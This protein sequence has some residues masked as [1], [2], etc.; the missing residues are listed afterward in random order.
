SVK[1]SPYNTL[2]RDCQKRLVFRQNLGWRQV[3]DLSVLIR[4][5]S[6]LDDHPLA[7]LAPPASTLPRRR[8][9]GHRCRTPGGMWYSAAGGDR[10]ARDG[11]GGRPR[12]AVA[13]GGGD[14]R[15]RRS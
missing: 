5:E 12:D 8:G 4:R 9:A 6:R 10:G 1:W 11:T 3:V 7:P 13:G 14:P 15:R 2:R